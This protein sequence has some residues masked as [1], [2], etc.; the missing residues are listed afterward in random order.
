MR[1]HSVAVAS[2]PAIRL[3][4]WNKPRPLSKP[5]LRKIECFRLNIL[6][7]AERDGTGLALEK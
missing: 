1:I 6:R 4:P 5:V 2:K 7:Q 3:R